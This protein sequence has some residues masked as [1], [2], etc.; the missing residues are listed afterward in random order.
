MFSSNSKPVQ[1]FLLFQ[2]YRRKRLI[3]VAQFGISDECH[4]LCEPEP[5]SESEPTPGRALEAEPVFLQQSRNSR[6]AAAVLLI[7]RD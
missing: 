5:E 2:M 6:N 3:G 4:N 1:R 7:D